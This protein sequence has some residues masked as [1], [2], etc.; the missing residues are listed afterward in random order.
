MNLQFKPVNDG[1]RTHEKITTQIKE[2]IFNNKF[3]PGDR[4][5]TE[6]ELAKIF[7]TSRVT[8]RQSILTLRN[9]G[10]LFVKIGTG[11]GTFVAQD[12]GEAEIIEIIENIIKWNRTGIYDV[13]QLREMIEPQVAYL[14]AQKATPEDLKIIWD[15]LNDPEEIMQNTSKFTSKDERFHKAIAKAAGNPILAI[16]QAAMID[17]WFKFVHEINWKNEEKENM[18]SHHTIIIKQIAAHNPEGAKDAMLNHLNDMKALLSKLTKDQLPV[19]HLDL[20]LKLKI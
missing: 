19:K 15:A 12:I 14:A 13:I 6:R 5:P 9:S 3:S 4:L 1:K 18:I 16:F 2:A 20:Q 7:N 8:I 10:M 11:G 17:I